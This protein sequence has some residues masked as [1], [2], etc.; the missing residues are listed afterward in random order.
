MKQN[1]VQRVTLATE[2]DKK[3]GFA[4]VKIGDILV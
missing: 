2:R 3:V 4:E 1:Y